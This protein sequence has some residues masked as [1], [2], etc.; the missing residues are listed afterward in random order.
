MS[1]PAWQDA[2]CAERLGL[3]CDVLTE[4]TG[5]ASA[6]A[7]LALEDLLSDTDFAGFLQRPHGQALLARVRAAHPGAE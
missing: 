3:W 4:R 5:S 2:R 6:A 1:L 7:R